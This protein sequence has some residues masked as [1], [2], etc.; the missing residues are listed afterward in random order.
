MLENNID[1]V[2]DVYRRNGNEDCRLKLV[3]ALLKI[4]K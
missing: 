2:G 3:I 1:L 4:G